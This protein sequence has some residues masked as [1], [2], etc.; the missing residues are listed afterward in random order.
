MMTNLQRLA[1][2]SVGKSSAQALSGEAPVLVYDSK[3]FNGIALFFSIIH[4]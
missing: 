1:Y 4:Q 2:H 3:E